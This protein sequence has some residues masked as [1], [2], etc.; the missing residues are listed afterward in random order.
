MIDSVLLGL[1]VVLVLDPIEPH[2]RPFLHLLQAGGRGR[3][4]LLDVA[5]L[6]TVPD[7]LGGRDWLGVAVVPLVCPRGAEGVAAFHGENERALK[8]IKWI[9]WRDGRSWLFVNNKYSFL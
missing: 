2:G 5:L 9:E 8:S 1:L 3:L 4:R 6:A 7:V